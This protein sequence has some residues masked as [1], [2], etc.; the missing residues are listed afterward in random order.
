LMFKG[1]QFTANSMKE[2]KR[3]SIGRL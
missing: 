1:L 3:K 2:Q